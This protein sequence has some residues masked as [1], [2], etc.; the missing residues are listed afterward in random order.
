ME[1]LSLKEDAITFTKLEGHYRNPIWLYRVRLTGSSADELAQ[2]LFTL[3]VDGDRLLILQE[4]DKHIDEHGNLFIRIDKQLLCKGQVS[5][6]EGNAMKVKLKPK[7][8]LR[9]AEKLSL[10]RRLLGWGP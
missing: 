5:P 6:S 7:S 2:H 1:L 9:P 8:I 4:F 3:M 10:Y